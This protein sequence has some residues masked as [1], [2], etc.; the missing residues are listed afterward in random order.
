MKSRL[1]KATLVIVGAVVL[2]TVGIFASDKLQGIDGGIGNLAGVRNASVCSDGAVPFK[3]D[4]GVLCVDMYE[5]SAGDACTHGQPTNVLQTEQNLSTK[6]CVVV[7]SEERTPWTFVSLPQAQR[8]CASVGK[9]LPTNKEWYHIALGTNP[10]TCTIE[11]SG[12]ENTGTKKECVSS[13]GAYDVVG[14]VW[15]WVDGTVAGKQ[16]EGRALP[17]EGYVTSVDANGVAI[18][19]G[20]NAD[21]LYGKDYF[22]SKS[23]GV[24]GI[25]RGGFY[26]SS[27]DAGLYT[28]NASVLTSFASL[29]VGFRCVE[30]VI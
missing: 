21:D 3:I 7:S 20:E 18:T 9:R 11:G 16:L 19:S 4:S 2:S 17:E 29:G 12:A 13:A 15:E 1:L 25:I 23:D 30:D 5:A 26:G 27:Q 28:M 8:L 22:W 14:N 6:E 10:D 24:F